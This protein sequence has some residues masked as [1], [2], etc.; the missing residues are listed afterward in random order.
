MAASLS[1][2]RSGPPPPNRAAR[3]AR[4]FRAED[5]TMRKIEAPDGY[6]AYQRGAALYLLA[7]P[8]NFADDRV[9]VVIALRNEDTMANRC[10]ACGARGPTR[11]ERR[12]AKRVA[13][14]HEPECPC[15]DAN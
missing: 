14:F 7:D 11:A 6:I 5:R 1:G 10:P 2:T 4:T 15:A 13:I 3:A 12:K 8:A 9:R